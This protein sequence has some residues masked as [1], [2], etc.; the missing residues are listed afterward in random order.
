MFQT[1]VYVRTNANLASVILADATVAHAQQL[2]VQARAAQVAREQADIETARIDAAQRAENR[3]MQRSAFLRRVR[4]QG[5]SLMFVSVP[6]WVLTPV[7]GS[8]LTVFSDNITQTVFLSG[9]SGATSG[10]GPGTLYGLL[11]KLLIAMIVCLVGLAFVFPYPDGEEVISS[12][13]IGGFA[14]GALLLFYQ[15][16]AGSGS[17]A[18][19][20]WPPLFAV[21]GHLVFGGIRMSAATGAEAE[22]FARMRI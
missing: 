11:A 19:W 2:A 20:W 6:L 21:A 13:G 18:S 9:D 10:S 7:V 12:A 1:E 4:G 16:L 5:F 22:P 15:A 14:L 3:R 8:I 17:A